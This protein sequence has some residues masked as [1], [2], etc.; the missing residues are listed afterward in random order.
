[1]LLSVVLLLQVLVL[2][3]VERVE[4]LLLMC[5]LGHVLLLLLGDMSHGLLL[6]V[7]LLLLLLGDVLLLLGRK[8]L[9]LLLD[10][11]LQLFGLALELVLFQQ[12]LVHLGELGDRLLGPATG[13]LGARVGRASSSRSARWCHHG[14]VAG[15]GHVSVLGRRAAVH[16]IATEMGGVGGLA[17]GARQIAVALH[18]SFTANKTRKCDS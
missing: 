6:L 4:L 9:E 7:L 5:L 1:M 3:L 14:L 16:V 17:G 8:R 13:L 10:H 18:L 11:V 12:L 15:D 2:M